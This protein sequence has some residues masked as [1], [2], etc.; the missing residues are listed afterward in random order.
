M[1]GKIQ[2]LINPKLTFQ[3][4]FGKPQV[5][6]EGMVRMVG[7]LIVAIILE[8]GRATTKRQNSAIVWKRIEGMVIAFSDG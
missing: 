4:F 5:N 8:Y 2:F 1:V 6:L 7:E 3:T